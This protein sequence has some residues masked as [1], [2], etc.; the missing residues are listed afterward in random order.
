MK[1]KRFIS[2]VAALTMSVSCFA[3]LTITANAA[4]PVDIVNINFGDESY[5]FNADTE[6]G[7]AASGETP[8]SGIM[9]KMPEGVT[10]SGGAATNKPILISGEEKWLKFDKDFANSLTKTLSETELNTIGDND[11][12]TISF[13]VAYGN[14]NKSYVWQA[15]KDTAG[16]TVTQFRYS[17]YTGIDAD[18]NDMN[19]SAGNFKASGNTGLPAYKV[20]YEYIWDY[21]RKSITLNV[22]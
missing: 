6:I 13:D 22:L 19:V 2:A 10:I 21:A 15:L 4:D 9:A 12:I 8:A 1:I 17:R 5:A 20:H 14:L 7:A 11:K 18:R 3:G 16:S